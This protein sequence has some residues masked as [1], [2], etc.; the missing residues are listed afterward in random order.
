MRAKQESKGISPDGLED[1]PLCARVFCGLGLLHDGGLLELF[2][3]VQLASVPASQLTHQEHF[4]VR[5][6]QH[7]GVRS[8]DS[9]IINTLWRFN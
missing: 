2:E 5:W 9:R 6:G 8:V 3:G 7:Q 1:L 4:A